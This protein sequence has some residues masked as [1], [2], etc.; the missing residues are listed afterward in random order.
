MYYIQDFLKV[1]QAE[2][3]TFLAEGRSPIEPVPND[4]VYRKPLP[5]TNQIDVIN[6]F[7]WFSGGTSSALTR[8]AVQKIP[9][10]FMV[11]KEQILNSQLSQALYYFQNIKRNLNNEGNDIIS[12]FRKWMLP[13]AG[14]GK[15]DDS[16][17][18]GALTKLEAV[19]GEGQQWVNENLNK[20]QKLLPT[21]INE[22]RLQDSYL[23]SLISLYLTQNTGFQYC[24][25]YFDSPPV[26]SNNWGASDSNN[27]VRGAIDAGMEVVNQISGV[28]NISQPGI[29][30]QEAKY[31][32]FNDEGPSITVTLPL[33]NTV[34]RG[35]KVPYVQN[36]EFLWLLMYQ[37]KPYKTSFARTMPPKI[38]D[39]TLPGMINWPYAYIKNLTVDF[40]GTV[41]NKN[42]YING[43]G[44]IQAPIPD[45]YMVTIELQSLLLDYANLMVGGGFGVK[46]ID[47]KVTVG[48]STDRVLGDTPAGDAPE[49][50]RVPEPNLDTPSA[51]LADQ[52]E[53][54]AVRSGGGDPG[55]E[56]NATGSLNP[57]P[58]QPI[59]GDELVIPGPIP[60]A[61]NPNIGP[62]LGVS[63][64]IPGSPI[65]PSLP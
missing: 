62:S 65:P 25:P 54:A 16:L 30:I 53:V 20:L 2:L 49:I 10:L 17:L 60:G 56:I 46:I 57:T 40:K 31:Y 58:I 50:G 23:S 41:R 28:T 51:T 1:E 37:N 26:I 61:G 32:G 55:S 36:Y 64:P 5:S 4:D 43:L 38:Y 11:E 22:K 14:K 6:E 3:L 7:S 34:R 42:F 29:Y 9:R 63:V 18:A 47:N 52:I 35:P 15:E 39:V 48:K 44:E 59:L 27:I 19:V 12:S 45:A 33:F 13:D 21:D 8:A 24:L